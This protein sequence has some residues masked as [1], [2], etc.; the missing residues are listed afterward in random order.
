MTEARLVARLELGPVDGECSADEQC[1]QQER[2]I[3][4]RLQ[5]MIDARTNFKNEILWFEQGSENMQANH[6]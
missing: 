6:E 5:S 3:H 4:F 2:A 1:K